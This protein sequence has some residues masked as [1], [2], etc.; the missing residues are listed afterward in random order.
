MCMFAVCP[1]Q[2]TEGL[3]A[4]QGVKRNLEASLKRAEDEAT[5]LTSQLTDSI[6]RAE[7]AELS[8][9]ALSTQLEEMKQT[10]AALERAQ[11][12]AAQWAEQAAKADA[13]LHEVR[14]EAQRREAASAERHAALEAQ[15]EASRAESS[16]LSERLAVAQTEARMWEEANKKLS[17]AA[18]QERANLRTLIEASDARAEA[19][20]QKL[21][22]EV[23][24][25]G[26]AEAAAAVASAEKQ[27]L[28]E[29]SG[30]VQDQML[31]DRALRDAAQAALET[32]RADGQT[33]VDGLLAENAQAVKRASK[34]NTEL[35]AQS[36][37]ALRL[38]AECKAEVQARRAVEEER[39]ELLKKIDRLQQLMT[40]ERGALVAFEEEKKR[41]ASLL[42]ERD[43]AEDGRLRVQE[44]LAQ[45]IEK[46][47]AA[48]TGR[49]GAEAAV[50]E[51]RSQLEDGSQWESRYREI[52]RDRVRTQEALQ[53]ATAEAKAVS[54]RE[55]VLLHRI[56]LRERLVNVDWSRGSEVVQEL[57]AESARTLS[58]LTTP[59]SAPKAGTPAGR[60]P[61]QSSVSFNG[62]T[63]RISP[64]A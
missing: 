7:R 32:A 58:S 35:R 46:L 12:D 2:A 28:Q 11:R 57:R 42:E 25:R 22:E 13:A 33:R 4:E 59:G 26:Q 24:A 48:E 27:M 62:S 52:E 60:S 41:S 63:A 10:H 15:R 17:E 14:S 19:V 23:G 8:T 45:T 3:V 36:E 49:R 1:P 38:E 51:A 6:H 44:Q 50:Q 34:L 55:Q 16:A 39:N 30:R 5:S 54:E 43:V 20:H 31:H 21:R 29:V 56:A 53:R 47:R 61:T 18:E 9:S 40:E 37:K 64:N